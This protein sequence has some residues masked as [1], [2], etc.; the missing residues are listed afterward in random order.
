MFAQQVQLSLLKEAVGVWRTM[1]QPEDS[2]EIQL[3]TFWTSKHPLNRFH[4]KA[5][6]TI[7]AFGALE[8]G[9]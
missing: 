9:F 7:Q 8:S 3:E 2:I 4:S 5:S 1:V 6:R